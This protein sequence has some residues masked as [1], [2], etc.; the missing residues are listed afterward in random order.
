MKRLITW[1]LAG[2]LFVT[3]CAPRVAYSDTVACSRLVTTALQ[4]M[5]DP[6]EYLSADEDHY[7]FYFGGQEGFGE[8]EDVQ[9][10]FHR[11]TTNV[12][13]LGVFRADDEEDVAAVRGMVEQYLHDQVEN[14][15][16]FAANYS[17][18]D[19]EKIEGAG[20]RVYGTYVVYYILND[21]DAASALEAV[22]QAIIVN[23]S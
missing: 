8:V 5:G 21:E 6:A 16:S 14:L 22:K 19:M 17:P 11:E 18:K 9:V 7:D 1:M 12:N 15:R 2:V 20:V 10:V 3:G 23:E 13:E 4:A